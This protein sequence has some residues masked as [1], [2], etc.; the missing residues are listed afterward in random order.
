VYRTGFEH[1]FKNSQSAL[2][3]NAQW[4]HVQSIESEPDEQSSG[5]HRIKR[6]ELEDFKNACQQITI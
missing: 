4:L 6:K 1:G 5:C 3:F 2:S